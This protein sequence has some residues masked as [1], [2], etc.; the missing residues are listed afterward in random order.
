MPNG[1]VEKNGLVST[2]S[3]CGGNPHPSIMKDEAHG[4]QTVDDRRTL[5]GDL[6]ALVGVPPRILLVQGIARIVDDVDKA[7]LDLLKVGLNRRQVVGQVDGQGDALLADLRLGENDGFRQN[8]RETRRVFS[9][10]ADRSG[11]RKAG[12]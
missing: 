2:G 6:E 3:S 12:S 10:F 11:H 4:R 7:L 1:L 8:G 5:A 9:L